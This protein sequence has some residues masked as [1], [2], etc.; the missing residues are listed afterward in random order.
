MAIDTPFAKMNGI[1]NQILVVDMRNNSEIITEQAAVKLA[2]NEE[3]KFDQIMAIHKAKTPDTDAYVNIINC[4]GSLAQA[5]GNGM[6]CVVQALVAETGQKEFRFETLAGLVKAI[7]HNDG[8][9]SVDMGRP[10]F[11]WHQIPL[12]EEFADTRGIELQI[13]PI[14][15]PILHTPSAMSIGNPHIIFWVEEDVWS[16]EL[17]LFG[18]VLE[19]HPMLPEGANISIASL[20]GKDELTMRTWERGAGLTLACGS[21]ACAGAVC[22]ART[23]RT[24]RKVGII[25]PGGKLNIEWD[26]NDKVIMTGAA[27]WEWSGFLDIKSGDYIP[28]TATH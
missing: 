2:G 15:A 28:D 19:N 3:T 17:D 24:G 8:L 20:T 12:A 7:E 6:R 21:A 27:E 9:I 11:L 26:E 10:R 25:M 22:A 23:G 16:Y 5:C 1:G 14:E 18:P 4:D 13:G